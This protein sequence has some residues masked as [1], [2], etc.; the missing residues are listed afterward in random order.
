[1]SNKIAIIITVMILVLG[2]AAYF[3]GF[4]STANATMSQ[5]ASN[6]LKSDSLKFK[7][8]HEPNGEIKIF[9]NVND[10]LLQKLKVD[11]GTST[12]VGNSIVIGS[13]EAMMMRNAKLINSINDKVDNL[14]GVNITIGA[15]LAPTNTV[16]DDLHFVSES[17]FESLDAKEDTMFV[18]VVDDKM[19]KLFYTLEAVLNQ[20]PIKIDLAEGSIANYETVTKDSVTYHPIIIGLAEANIMRKEK[21]FAKTGDTL[22]DFFGNNVI[23]AG[24]QKQTN[25]SLDVLHILP[26]TAKDVN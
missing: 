22:K 11:Q 17:I 25:T 5:D 6:L 4:S 15:I 8:A 12:P 20:T 21:M 10:N 16:I 19:A 9:V 13:S 26:L 2:S 23:I 14:F 3:S 1:M 24:I 7:V 18:R